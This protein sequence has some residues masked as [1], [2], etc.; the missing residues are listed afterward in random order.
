MTKYIAKVRDRRDNQVY[1]RRRPGGMG[2]WWTT[3]ESEAHQFD[4]SEQALEA[5]NVASDDYTKMAIGVGE[6][7]YAAGRSRS[8]GDLYYRAKAATWYLTSFAD[9]AHEFSSR[10]WA[11]QSL[12]GMNRG[13]WD[14]KV[15]TLDEIQKW[16]DQFGKS[17][18]VIIDDIGDK[19]EE[20]KPGGFIVNPQGIIFHHTAEPANQPEIVKIRRSVESAVS[21]E[22]SWDTEK[23]GVIL[24]LLGSDLLEEGMTVD[25]LYSV[26]F[27]LHE[28]MTEDDES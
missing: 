6:K 22:L 11:S 23:M 26:L 24:D 18:P 1:Y 4:T 10:F 21:S 8:N 5:A 17:E 19:V 7:I 2:P 25:K 28:E 16:Y 15:G 12:Q 9:T 13:F 14:F 27:D 3:D 20:F